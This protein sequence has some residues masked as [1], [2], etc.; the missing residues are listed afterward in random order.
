MSDSFR[1]SATPLAVAGWRQLA[2]LFLLAV[3]WSSSFTFIKIGVAT[4]PPATMVAC[5]LILAAVILLVYARAR[6]HRIPFTDAAWSTFAFVGIVG[7][8]IPFALIAWGE[9]FVDSGLAAILMGT[10]PVA[11][12]LL[13]HAFTT[14]E[15]LTPRRISGVFYLSKLLTRN[16]MRLN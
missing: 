1:S 9:I 5:R 3:I 10:M 4:I 16:S 14:D 6:G 13:A 7:N 2:L 11:T 15:K 12:A 8:V